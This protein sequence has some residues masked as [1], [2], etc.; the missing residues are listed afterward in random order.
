MRSYRE[1]VLR[2]SCLA[3]IVVQNS[4]LILVTSYSRTLLPAY[5]P[6]VAVCFAEIFKVLAAVVLLILE[7]NSLAVAI[8]QLRALMA[9]HSRD[10]LLFAIPAFCYT[11]QNNL[12]CALRTLRAQRLRHTF[13]LHV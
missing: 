7:S 12:W 1:R 10:T 5:L 2:I 13:I 8:R 11:V 9:E 6:S 4:S 3:L